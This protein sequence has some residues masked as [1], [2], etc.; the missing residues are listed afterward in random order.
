MDNK[1][2]DRFMKNIL[3]IITLATFVSGSYAQEEKKFV[4]KGNRQYEKKNFSEAEINY[5]KAAEQKAGSGIAAFNLG[6]SL[7]KQSKF[8][9]AGK[10]F[11]AAANTSMDKK[12]LAKAF[13]NLGNSFLQMQK[14]PESIEAYKKALRNNPNDLETKYNLS[15]AQKKMNE[16]PNQNQQNQK[17]Q[18]KNDQNKNDQN[19][20]KNKDQDKNQNQDQQNE[21]DNQGQNDQN[22]QSQAN[23]DKMSKEDAERLLQA[24]QNDENNTQDKLK[25]EKAAGRKANPEIDW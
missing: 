17:D 5:R 25:K 21:Q 16:N 10:E 11:S 20:D 3:L 13:H 7:Y 4:R 2:K 6:N 1:I 8:E 18:N 15:F 22:Q 14:Y 12:D 24:I 9:E 19:Q 23:K